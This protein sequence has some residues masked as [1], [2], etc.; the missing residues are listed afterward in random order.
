M[1]TPAPC[2]TC[3]EPI[4]RAGHLAIQVQTAVFTALDDF[5]TSISA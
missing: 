2:P 5:F 1:P 3:F 4:P